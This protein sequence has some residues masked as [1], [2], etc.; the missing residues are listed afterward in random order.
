LKIFP[1]VAGL[2]LRRSR[3]DGLKPHVEQHFGKAMT[4]FWK[5]KRKASNRE[6]K[7]KREL[8]H[9]TQD[10][11]LVIR[12]ITL[13]LSWLGLNSVINH[14]SFHFTHTFEALAKVND[15]CAT[16]KANARAQALTTR[17]STGAPQPLGVEIFQIKDIIAL[18]CVR[19]CENFSRHFIFCIRKLSTFYRVFL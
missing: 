12:L 10:F 8:A 15:E 1:I 4:V 3:F 2:K 16:V 11:P 6:W 13:I 5:N 14:A 18:D 17:E 9:L 7:T 19:L